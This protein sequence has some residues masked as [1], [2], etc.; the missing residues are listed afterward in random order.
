LPQA[1]DDPIDVRYVVA[2][3]P[4]NVRRAG[5]LLFHRST[6]LLRKSR[7]QNCVTEADR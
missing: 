7:I 6:V 2:A 4:E 3:K 5:K 1:R